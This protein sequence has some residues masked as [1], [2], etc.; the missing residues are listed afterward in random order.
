M[1]KIAYKFTVRANDSDIMTASDLNIR[2]NTNIKKSEQILNDF[3]N[4]IKNWCLEM[5]YTKWTIEDNDIN[6]FTEI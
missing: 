1:K 6:T 3:L 2:E 5:Y 4:D